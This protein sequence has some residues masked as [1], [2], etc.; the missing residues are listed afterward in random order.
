MSDSLADVRRTLQVEGETLL[1]LAQSIGGE[2]ADAIDL[3]HSCSGRVI[4][5]GMGK[6][7]CVARKAAGTFASTGTPAWFVH[8]G[9][10]WHGDLGA[11]AP[12]DVVLALSYSGETEE[13]LRLVPHLQRCNIPLVAITGQRTNALARRSQCVIELAIAGEADPDCPAPTCSTTAMLA[14]CDA[15]AVALM[16]RRGLTREQFALLHPGGNLGRKLLLT[17]ADLMHGPQALPTVGR[18]ELLRNVIVAMSRGGMGAVFIVAQDD[19]LEGIFTDGDLRRALERSENPWGSPIEA[20]MS[21]TPRVAAA[22]ELAVRALQRMEVHAIT[23]LPVIESNGRL[24]G[25]VR[26]HDLVK[27]HLV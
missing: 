3:M 21:A 14:V 7:G 26:L 17:V 22:D 4:V 27:A 1:A 18:A 23:L 12:G 8:P 20:W 2:V 6:A 19:R 11:I 5:L 10:A 9:E 15:L 24:C 25:A 16:R 13:V